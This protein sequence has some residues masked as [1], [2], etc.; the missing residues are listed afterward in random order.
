MQA[1]LLV[2]DDLGAEFLDAKGF[3]GSLSMS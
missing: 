1:P 3:F 2:I